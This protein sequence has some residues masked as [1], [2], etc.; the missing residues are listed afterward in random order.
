MSRALEENASAGLSA[1]GGRNFTQPLE[2]KE[3]ASNS[4]SATGGKESDRRDDKEED[5]S[6]GLPTTGRKKIGHKNHFGA[7]GGI[8]RR[9]GRITDFI[10][11][12]FN[13]LFEIEIDGETELIPAVDDFIVEF[14]ER[15][16]K[17]VFSLPEGLIGLNK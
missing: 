6:D 12:E 16:R 14:D 13:P 15:C 1:T 3:N 7:E 8:D 17:V 10:D 2:P 11:S 5:A 9:S 4:L